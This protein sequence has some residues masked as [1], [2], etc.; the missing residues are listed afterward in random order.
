MSHSDKS[1]YYQALKSLGREFDKPYN[2]YTTAELKEMCDA[3]GLSVALPAPPPPRQRQRQSQ[4]QPQ[5]QEPREEPKFR[6]SDIPFSDEPVEQF[7]GELAYRNS[8]DAPVR[9]DSSGRVWFRE[10][11]RKPSIPK[12]RRRRKIK[13]IDPGTKTISAR[14]G[15]YTETFEV[16]GE[17]R[18]ESEVSMTLPSYQV[19]IYLHPAFPFR[20]H[21]YNGV[22]GFDLFEVQE[23]YGAADLVPSEIKRIYVEND[24]C[25]DIRTTVR[26][27][28]DEYRRN[29]L[30]THPG[31]Q[32]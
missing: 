11:I 15:E 23:F 30:S 22:E 4:P 6:M 14:V 18:R 8:E 26:A 12:E 21:C 32:L 29:Q 17:G 13:Y 28:N 27:I 16:A 5:Y 31:V 19:G 9:R 24:L 10:E 3:A 1:A 25:Y 2:Q 20:I 7:A